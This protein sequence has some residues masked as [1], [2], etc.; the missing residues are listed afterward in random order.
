[1]LQMSIYLRSQLACK[2]GT[3]FDKRQFFKVKSPISAKRSKNLLP[4]TQNSWEKN[5]IKHIKNVYYGCVHMKKKIHQSDH[6]TNPNSPSVIKMNPTDPTLGPR[7][8][9]RSADPVW[10]EIY[11][12]RRFGRPIWQTVFKLLLIVPSFESSSSSPC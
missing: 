11:L 2:V 3:E 5:H 7:G 8:S 1:M 9:T 4:R 10:Q 12:P 6:H